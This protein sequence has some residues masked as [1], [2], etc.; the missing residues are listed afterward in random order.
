MSHHDLTKITCSSIVSAFDSVTVGT[1]VLNEKAFLEL[2][3][4]AVEST[5]FSAQRVEGQALI[6]LAKAIPFVSCGVGKGT[7]QV[8]DYILREY[9]GKVCKFLKRHL[10]S[11]VKSL[12]VVVYTREAYL[13]DPDVMKNTEE[14]DRVASSDATHVLIT[15]LASAE[16]PS[17]LSSS[18]F[19]RNLAGGNN[20]FLVLSADEIREKAKEVV[21]YEDEGWETVAD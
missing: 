2:L 10:A 15:V 9:R 12:A 3:I 19:V 17:S 11:E 18:R 5:D 8:E 6:P 20:E 4:H 13:K 14:W 16:T 1:K 21:D 7:N